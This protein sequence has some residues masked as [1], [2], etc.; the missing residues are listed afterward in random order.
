MV[1]AV[2]PDCYWRRKGGDYQLAHGDLYPDKDL[3]ESKN[4]TIP[5]TYI[6]N[7][8]LLTENDTVFCKFEV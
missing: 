7:S 3:S 5:K 4:Q 6:P 1:S 8:F 2:K